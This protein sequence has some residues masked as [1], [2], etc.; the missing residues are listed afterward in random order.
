MYVWQPG[1]TD[2]YSEHLGQT[3]FFSLHDVKLCHEFEMA[4]QI[5]MAVKLKKNISL[6]VR[7]YAVKK[8]R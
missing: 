6:N 5:F 2:D 3:F 8:A 7:V 4:I 1:A